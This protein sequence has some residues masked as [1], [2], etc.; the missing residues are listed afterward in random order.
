[1]SDVLLTVFMDKK[2]RKKLYAVRNAKKASS[3]SSKVVP[4]LTRSQSGHEPV[5]YINENKVSSLIRKS[6]DTAEKE[7]IDK[8]RSPLNKATKFAVSQNREDL[9]ENALTIFKSK[10]YIIDELPEEQRK[11]LKHLAFQV[12]GKQLKDG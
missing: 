1:M 4:A 9:I 8:E 6:R 3:V 2:A 7:V 11:K 10:S 5:S 12:F